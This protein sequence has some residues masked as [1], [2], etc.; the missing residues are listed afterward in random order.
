MKRKQET[1]N[2]KLLKTMRILEGLRGLRQLVEV[3]KE[4]LR[5]LWTK[6]KY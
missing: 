6:L 2:L 1:I 5:V 3:L 4:K